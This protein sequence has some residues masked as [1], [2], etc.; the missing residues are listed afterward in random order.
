[1]STAAENG[2]EPLISRLVARMDADPGFAGLGS[3]IQ[4]IAELADDENGA[5]AIAAAILR[6]AALTARLLKLAN[7]S[8]HHGT[9]NVT[10]VD[11]A[12]VILGLKTVKSVAMSM[13]LLNAL[14]SKP[15]SAQ[16]HAE[17]AASYFCGTLAAEITRLNAPR[18]NQQE[19]QVCGLLQNLGRMMVLYYAYGD[20]EQCR[21][22]QITENISEEEAVE[23]T[24]GVSFAEI[25]SA[26]AKHWNLPY[27]IQQSLEPL[28]G[29]APPR[30][31]PAN[32]VGWHQACTT[33]A[34]RV[35]DVLFRLPENRERSELGGVT[36]FFR[37]VLRL[38]EEETQERIAFA[39]QDVDNLLSAI[40]FPCTLEQARTTLRKTSE[41]ALDILS[42]QDSLT[43]HKG[44][45]GRTPIER[46]QTTLRLI[47][48]HFGFDRT[49]LCLPEGAS[50]LMAI[51]GVGRNAAAI[52]PKFRCFGPRQD[53]FRIVM[54]KRSDVYIAN[55]K[56]PAYE[57]LFPSWYGELVGAQS[58]LLLPI[59]H[60]A[61]CLGLLYGDF[62]MP[63]DAAPQG[64]AGGVVMDWRKDIADALQ[65]GKPKSQT[66]ALPPLTDLRD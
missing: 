7:A 57:K 15:Q 21:T 3:S 19:A 51:A 66:G 31:V 36:E 47:H 38:N 60:G 50:G 52:T 42:A 20:I 10:T 45:G 40:S 16:L 53:L 32:A 28:V 5:R 4:T 56:T 2:A 23:R 1:M 17:I 27:V 64:Y 24:L 49:L 43:R 58:C 34:R 18:F 44:E 26:I 8:S 9:R 25:G 55:A 30:A 35:T 46:I 62:A 13:A 12:L 37:M 14:S 29:K 22:L 61:D 6:D 65:S 39:L 48:E 54:A 11:Q 41:R 63:P 33:F 59:V